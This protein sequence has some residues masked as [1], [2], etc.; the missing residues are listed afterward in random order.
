MF[1]AC[2]CA[3]RVRTRIC[4]C[5][6]VYDSVCVCD[7]CVFHLDIFG[8]GFIDLENEGHNQAHDLKSIKRHC[9][10]H[11]PENIHCINERKKNPISS[12]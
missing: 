4:V 10:D 8:G 12:Q 1:M 2:V 5:V 9:N 11:Y 6:R 3:C 7:Q